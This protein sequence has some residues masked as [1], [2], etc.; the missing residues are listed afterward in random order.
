MRRDEA[1]A[2]FDLG[3]TSATSRGVS[4]RW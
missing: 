4:Y 3:E 1:H 2:S